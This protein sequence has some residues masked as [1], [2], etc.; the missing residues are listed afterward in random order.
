MRAE[1]SHLIFWIVGVLLIFFVTT[2]VTTQINHDMQE[3]YSFTVLEK[4]TAFNIGVG[5]MCGVVTGYTDRS[6]SRDENIKIVE[7]P[8]WDM[9]KIGHTYE[10]KRTDSLKLL[11]DPLLPLE[12]CR[13]VNE[14]GV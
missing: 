3:P 11:F 13:E 12:T 4:R 2:M 7:C 6:L 5:P 14:T 8:V 1:F 10:C 9:M